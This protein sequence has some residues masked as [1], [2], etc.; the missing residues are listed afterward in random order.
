MITA[1]DLICKYTETEIF[2]TGA[3][4]YQWG[5]VK[6]KLSDT[7][8]IIDR[9]G[10]YTVK[11]SDK[12]GC[13]NND[14]VNVEDLEF[15]IEYTTTDNPCFGYNTGSIKITKIIGNYVA[16]LFHF[17]KDLGYARYAN[18]MSTDNRN[19]LATGFY[20]VYSKDDYGCFRYDTIIINGPKEKSIEAD[21]LADSYNAA[22]N[23]MITLTDNTKGNPIIWLW[24]L[25]NGNTESDSVARVNFTKEGNYNVNLYVEDSNGCFDSITKRIYIYDESTIYIPNA[26]TP[27]GDGINDIFKPKI[28]V[29]L[30]EGYVFEI[31]NRLGQKVFSTTDTENGWDG[32]IGGKPVTTTTIYS[33]RIVARDF[34]GQDHEYVGH[35]TLI[36]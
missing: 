12:S 26:F 33:Y 11:G 30:K 15:N 32:K 28:L 35:V 27:N 21:F 13:I 2:A 9:G 34:T 8:A 20:I 36:K 1:P 6:R 5:G 18:G 25:D 4:T 22:T 19:K 24:D 7:S 17:W 23:T 10:M 14:T 29:D 31:F 3:T 16:P